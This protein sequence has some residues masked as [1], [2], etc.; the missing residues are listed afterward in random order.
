MPVSHCL[1]LSD[2]RQLDFSSAG[3]KVPQAEFWQFCAFSTWVLH[4]K[5]K[6]KIK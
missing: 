6:N 1:L 2:S 3:M 5:I 4:L